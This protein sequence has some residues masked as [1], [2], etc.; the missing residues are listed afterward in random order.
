MT[1]Q[2]QVILH[3]FWASPYVKGVELALKIKGIPY[4]YVEEDLT[5]KSTLLLKYNPVHK[6]VPV[7]I[8]N[9]K[10]IAESLAIIEYIDETWKDGPPILPRDPYK[11]SQARFWV[12]FIPQHLFTAMILVLKTEGEEQQKVVKEVFEK[13]TLLENGMK[14][15]FT[16]GTATA[17]V[18]SENMGLVDIFMCSFIGAH[19]IHEEV[20]GI[21][22]INP[23]KFPMLFSWLK[24]INEL[25]LVKELA[26]PYEKSLGLVQSL[27]QNALKSTAA[28]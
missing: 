12:N 5:T 27:R 14:D 22:F 3:G 9:G 10:P 21:K 19:R 11:R 24:A 13:L 28:A 7:L 15:F 16:Y 20:L 17:S 1:E 6:K 4:E 2:K 23:E 25:P 18:E 26:P 8:H